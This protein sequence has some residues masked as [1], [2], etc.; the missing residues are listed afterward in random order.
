MYHFNQCANRFFLLLLALAIAL[1]SCDLS[2]EEPKPENKQEELRQQIKAWVQG[3]SPAGQTQDS[4]S[5]RSAESTIKFYRSRKFDPLWITVDSI[6]SSAK[7]L[8]TFI[9]EA[10]CYGLFPEYYHAQILSSIRS[11]FEQDTLGTGARKDLG[12]WARMDILLT[13]AFLTMARHIH[14]GHLPLDSLVKEKNYSIDFYFESLN[15]AIKTNN[16][17]SI[18]LTLEPKSAGYQELKKALPNFLRRAQFKKQYTFVQYPFQDSLQFI[19]S[20]VI[21]LQEERYIDT[22]IQQLDSLELSGI[23]KKVQSD[24]GLKIDGKY[25]PQLIRSLNNNDIQKFNA[26]AINLDRYRMA[27]DTLPE[28][29]LVV[30]LPA[31]ELMVVDQDTVALSSRVI[32]GKPKTPTPILNSQMGQLIVFPTWTI[33]ASIIADEILPAVKRNPG[34]LAKKGYG[35]YDFEGNEVDPYTVDWSRYKKGIPYKIVQGEG[36]GNALGIM[37]FN[38][39]NEHGVYLHDTNQRGLFQNENRSLSHGCV[40]VQNWQGLYRYLISLDSIQSIASS[41]SYTRT[42]SIVHWLKEQ[43][44]RVIPLKSNLPIYFRYYTAAGKKGKLEL[45]N[46]VYGLDGQLREWL[47]NDR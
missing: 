22:S 8:I 23:L 34:Y 30:N 3:I 46:D 9:Q 2:S 47:K 15:K 26:A 18:L 38:F 12:Q 31:F 13:D 36:I 37:K 33:P 35:L 27:Q 32:V 17:D 39:Q 11:T 41:S 6:T 5:I 4:S 16:P 43:K 29:Y 24:R 44:R 21:R 7:S 40:R 19:R 14:R 45:Y 28:K 25:G 10:R 1:T 20:L 42:D